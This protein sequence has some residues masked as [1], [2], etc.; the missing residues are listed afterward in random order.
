MNRTFEEVVNSPELVDGTLVDV[1][2]VGITFKGKIV[3]KSQS[4]LIP[5]YI[6]ECLDGFI[7]NEVYGYK[8]LS[9]PVSEISE[10]KE[11]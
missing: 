1:R 11:F 9:I 8:F 6:V 5:H 7:P 3:G 2:V 10:K 4:G